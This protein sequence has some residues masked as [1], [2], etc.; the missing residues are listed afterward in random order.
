MDREQKRETKH[1]NEVMA[2]NFIFLRERKNTLTM[3]VFP[4]NLPLQA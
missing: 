3:N 1:I 4:M 2:C